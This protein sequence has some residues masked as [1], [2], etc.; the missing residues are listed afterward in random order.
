MKITSIT[1]TAHGP[2]NFEDIDTCH[3]QL[4]CLA[5]IDEVEALYESDC[6]IGVVTDEEDDVDLVDTFIRNINYNEEKG[7]VA[8]VFSDG[9]VRKAQ[10]V[11]DDQ[12]DLN[13]GVALCIAEKLFDT[14]SQ[15]HKKVAELAAKMKRKSEKRAALKEYKAKKNAKNEKAK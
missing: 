8:V 6:E 3:V 4:D 15:F 5:T 9:D 10:K 11:G 1:T 2:I 13:V 7:V 14:K 12:F